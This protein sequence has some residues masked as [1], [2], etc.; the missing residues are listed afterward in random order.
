[1]PLF[2]SNKEKPHLWLVK[3]AADPSPMPVENR[4]LSEKNLEPKRRCIQFKEGAKVPEP[5]ADGVSCLSSIPAL[6]PIRSSQNVRIALVG[7]TGLVG[8]S[9]ASFLANHPEM[10][11]SITH[12]IGSSLSKDR[13][14]A[15]VSDEKEKKLRSHY[16]EDFWHS[17]ADVDL[18][19]LKDAVVCDIEALLSSGPTSCDVVLSF[20]AP[21]LGHLEDEMIH[22]GFRVVSISPHKRMDY[23]LI[24]PVVNGDS[25][26]DRISSLR[27]VKSPNCCSVGSTVALLPLVDS[28]TVEQVFITTFQT[29]SGRGDALYPAEKVVGNVYP[30]GAT[31][32]RTE[33]YI[34]REVSRV[35]RGHPRGAG[36]ASGEGIHVSAYRVYVQKNHL[37][38]IRVKIK[39]TLPTPSTAAQ[40]FLEAMYS[41]LKYAGDITVNTEV[42]E[43]RPRSHPDCQKVTVGN[44]S[45]ES[46]APPQTG[47]WVRVSATVDNVGKGAWGNAMDI[48]QQVVA[49]AVQS[50]SASRD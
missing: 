35:F 9:C 48:T 25:V 23:P 19:A 29:L 11:Y 27:C 24:V 45:V 34:S 6:Q 39:E 22:A 28:F 1:M 3:G 2:K 38:D 36:L 50:S 44:F 40:A 31:E 46:L 47:S 30:I 21:R 4:T 17:E 32:E 12:F 16:G 10:G 8:R 43:P 26:Q 49:A 13:D 33:E 5:R 18:S 41:K 15:D 20:L 14:L 37:L 7:A 42:G